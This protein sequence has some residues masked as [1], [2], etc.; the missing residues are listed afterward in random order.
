MAERVL[1]ELKV[2][3]D[4]ASRPMEMKFFGES[5]SANVSKELRDLF[6]SYEAL[7]AERG[8]LLDFRELE[9]MNSSSF[10]PIVE[11]IRDLH[12]R[13]SP[14]TVLYSQSKPWQRTPFTAISSIASVYDNLTVKA[15]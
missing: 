9:Y 12:T 14:V 2:V 8:L 4:E 10:P 11:L 15:C 7:A 5:D 13:Q 1:G 3:V 6:G